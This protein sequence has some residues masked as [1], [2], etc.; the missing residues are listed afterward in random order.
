V[1]SLGQYAEFMAGKLE[2]N[3]SKLD[4]YEWAVMVVL[5]FHHNYETGQ[6]NPTVETI[7][8][9]AHMSPREVQR[10]AKK[11]ERRGWIRRLLY[12]P[13]GDQRYCYALACLGYTEF[14]TGCDAP[15]DAPGT[16]ASALE[17]EDCGEAGE[18]CDA[19]SDAQ[20]PP[21]CPP[22]TPP[23]TN[24]HPP[25]VHQTPPPGDWQSPKLVSS[26]TG[27]EEGTEGL[28]GSRN[29]LPSGL[30]TGQGRGGT[31]SPQAPQS[32]RDGRRRKGRAI[33]AQY[34]G[35]CHFCKEGIA[36][37]DTI[38]WVKGGPSAHE[39]CYAER[40]GRAPE[41][42]CPPRGSPPGPAAPPQQETAAGRAWRETEEEL[43]MLCRETAAARGGHR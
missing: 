3:P 9:E 2:G 1:V 32:D 31:T 42:P 36:V 8:R 16:E 23:A 22:V 19:G 30:T 18:G 37:G 26:L 4:H 33:P 38:R 11:L 17:P 7:A 28:N 15:C 39:S 41:P 20:Q 12:G 5:C 24:G 34:P 29:R 21:R 25:G 6:C 10:A 40:T 35:T 13:V 43:E 27:K 14:V